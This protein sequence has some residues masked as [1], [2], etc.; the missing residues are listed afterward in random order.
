MISLPESDICLKKN[1]QERQRVSA[2]SLIAYADV[3]A[4]PIEPGAGGAD[5]ERPGASEPD[6]TRA[7]L[8]ASSSGGCTSGVSSQ[9]PAYSP[10]SG[11][12]RDCTTIADARPKVMYI[13][14]IMR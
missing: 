13:C 8:C 7:I 11:S 10:P 1:E 6:R 9:N 4:P 5:K 12:G 3:V 2:G 14:M